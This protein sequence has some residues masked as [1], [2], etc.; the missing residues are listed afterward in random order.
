MSS[1]P[2]I[3][4]ATVGSLPKP[5]WLT[6]QWYGVHESWKLQGVA[7]AEALDDATMIAI[8]EQE[9]AGIDIVCDGEQRRS[10]HYSYILKD[11][12]GI[13]ATMLAPKTMRGGKVTQQVPR[14]VAE[15]LNRD[16]QALIDFEFLRRRTSKAIKMTLPGPTTLVDGTADQFY[17]DERSLAFAFAAAL[18]AQI[19]ALEAAGCD[20]VQLDEPAFTRLPG[21]T[22][23][24]GV[25]A[26][27]RAFAGTS[28]AS[29]VHI[30][31][32]YGAWNAATGGKQWKHGYE[33][34]FPALAR[35]S[36][37]QFS[38]E[39][40]EPNLAPTILRALSGKTIQLGVIDCG[41]H[42][43]ETPEQVAARLRAAVRVV[44]PDRLIAAPDCGCVALTRQSARGKLR[45]LVLGTEQ[46]RR[47]IGDGSLGSV[48]S[49]TQ[50]PRP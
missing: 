36:V 2:L 32:G 10:T 40:A 16:H 47:E 14:I 27:E 21:K 1:L 9:T 49:A 22:L 13:D 8:L 25:D 37:Q 3:P 28:I 26:L 17:G 35:S 50:A 34:I 15:V 45:A 48:R 20:M 44:G 43:I 39:F 19:K 42:D 23:A 29:C 38:L 7:L 11:F 33:E 24:Y 5:S 31:Y 18:N 46:V 4:T 41:N 30:C 6:D 12:S